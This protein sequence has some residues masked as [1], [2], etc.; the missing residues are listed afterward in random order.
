MVDIDKTVKLVN[1]ANVSQTFYHNVKKCCKY[2]KYRMGDLE[3][4]C[5]M[6]GGELSRWRKNGI[7]LAQAVDISKALDVDLML[8]LSDDIDME[9]FADR[10][11]DIY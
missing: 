11:G 6:G 5:G 10:K 3:K 1:R 8:L 7:L 9:Q 4:T 2:F